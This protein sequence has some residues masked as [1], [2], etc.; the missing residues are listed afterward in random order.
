LLVVRKLLRTNSPHV[1]VVLMSATFETDYY[2]SY[3]SLRQHDSLLVPPIIKVGE[4]PHPV[5]LFYL[6]DIRR[7]GD[8]S[9]GRCEWWGNVSGG[10][11]EWWG[12][13]SGGEM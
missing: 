7:L 10:R 8:V 2:A 13:V 6:D 5:H 11:C 12:D 3:F 9:G 1:K 4:S